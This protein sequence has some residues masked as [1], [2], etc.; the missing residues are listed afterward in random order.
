MCCQCIRTLA[1]EGG[2]VL[3][4]NVSSEGLTKRV[5]TPKVAEY[6][7]AS[8]LLPSHEHQSTSTLLVVQRVAVLI[9]TGSMRQSLVGNQGSSRCN[10]CHSAAR[11]MLRLIAAATA[12][13]AL[14]GHVA[15]LLVD[16]LRP[17]A[18]QRSA[19]AL[20]RSSLTRCPARQFSTPAT[21]LFGLPGNRRSPRT[22]NSP[23]GERS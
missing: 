8:W 21:R 11:M 6:K 12:L 4:D 23:S 13:L 7:G 3:G 2:G 9:G 18:I 15:A 22:S 19:R 17:D 10:R 14:A 5:P 1:E 20:S 16:H